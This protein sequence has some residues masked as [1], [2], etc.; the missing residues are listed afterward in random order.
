MKQERAATAQA[1]FAEHAAEWDRIRSLHVAEAD[2]EA[3]MRAALGSGPFELL[4]DLG[5]GTGRALELFADRYERALGIDANQ[6]MLGYARAKLDRERMPCAQVRHGDIY[7][8]GLDDKVA[9]AVVMHQVLHFLDDPQRA[10]REAARILAP[11]GRLLIV[12][13]APHDLEFLREDFAH[14]RLGFA[15]EQVAQWVEQAGLEQIAVRDL[16]PPQS[17]DGEA[18]KLTVSLWLAT[19]PRAE[20]QRSSA[21]ALEATS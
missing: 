16:V 2:V 9:G 17:G 21:D 15:S 20:P 6:A 13:F 5:T 18:R 4:V 3:A 14:Q 19:R 10:I 1:F 8:L 11:G 12:D 7:N